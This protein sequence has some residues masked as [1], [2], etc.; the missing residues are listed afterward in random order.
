MSWTGNVLR[1]DLSVGTCTTEA[2]NMEWAQDYMGQKGLANKYLVEETDAKVD[3]L[4]PDNKMI[5]ATGPLTSTIAPTS[6][7][8]S[9]VCKGTLTGA[10][11]CSN[12]GGF[13]GAD[14]T[15]PERLLRDAAKTGPAK[16]HVNRLD[17]M[18]PPEYYDLRGWDTSGVPTAETVSRL[19]L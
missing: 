12:S 5:F 7:R 4:S 9:V 14:D 1:V 15:L 2:T 10:I 13:T 18:M 16:G 6:G 3:P 11:A 8:W 19:G 17:E